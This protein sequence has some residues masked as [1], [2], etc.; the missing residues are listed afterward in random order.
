MGE[1]ADRL[2]RLAD[3][4]ESPY[5]SLYTLLY[6]TASDVRKMEDEN[7]RYRQAI[8]AFLKDEDGD[9]PVAPSILKP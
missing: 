9:S 6:D 4:A 8:V 2:D 7:D 3:E 5:S 1:L